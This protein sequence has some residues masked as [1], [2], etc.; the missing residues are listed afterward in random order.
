M[1]DAGVDGASFLPS[2]SRKHVRFWD[3]VILK[4]SSEA[5][6]FPPFPSGR[7]RRASP[8]HR[9]SQ[10]VSV[11]QT[12]HG[13]AM[14]D[15]TPHDHDVFVSAEAQTLSH[16]GALRGEM[17]VRADFHLFRPPTYGH[18][19]VRRADEASP[20]LRCAQA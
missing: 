2:F 3:E 17:D 10:G 9:L 13:I 7:R 1:W 14:S 20:H 18:A 5:R 8:P 12:H 16:E 19:A 6:D 4:I 15:R 11:D